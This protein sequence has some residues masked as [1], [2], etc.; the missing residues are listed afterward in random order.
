MRLCLIVLIFVQEVTCR[1]GLICSFR[2][3]NSSQRLGLDAHPFVIVTGEPT[4][5]NLTS[6]FSGPCVLCT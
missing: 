6:P 5:S 4:L 2:W 1:A 3:I